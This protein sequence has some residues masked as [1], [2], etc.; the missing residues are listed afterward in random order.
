MKLSF[1]MEDKMPLETANE[2][3]LV[4]GEEELI[5]LAAEAG[6]VVVDSDDCCDCVV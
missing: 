5:E 3:D 2:P 4:I 6:Q 1:S